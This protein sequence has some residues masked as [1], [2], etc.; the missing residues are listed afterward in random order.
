MVAVDD[1]PINQRWMPIMR[2]A[3]LR[4]WATV[5]RL[6]E[7]TLT[8]AQAE[9]EFHDFAEREEAEQRAELAAKGASRATTGRAQHPQRLYHSLPIR[10]AAALC[11]AE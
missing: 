7:G 9:A 1:N 5:A 11:L 6:S 4:D 10:T 3:K 2:A 8:E